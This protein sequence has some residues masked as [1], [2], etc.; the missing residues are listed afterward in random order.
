MA[1]KAYGTLLI[2]LAAH[3][4]PQVTQALPE[5]HRH[6]L[7]AQSPPEVLR[8]QPALLGATQALYKFSTSWAL[9]TPPTSFPSISSLPATTEG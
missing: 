9:P 2:S 4:A 8:A 3:F 5:E 7:P 1:Y 6:Q